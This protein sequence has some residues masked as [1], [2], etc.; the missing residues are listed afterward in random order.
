MARALTYELMREKMNIEAKSRKIS[1]PKRKDRRPI[2]TKK[3][4]KAVIDI[5]WLSKLEGP[6]WF[7]SLKT[8]QIDKCLETGAKAKIIADD[9]AGHS[10]EVFIPKNQINDV[11]FKEN[12]EI[13]VYLEDPPLQ[14]GE[15]NDEICLA[16]EQKADELTQ[17]QTV[18][19][20]LEKKQ[21][22]PGVLM[23][24]VKGGYVVALLAKDREQAEAGVGL[25]AFL[26]MQKSSLVS[27]V[28]LDVL[29][30][31]VQEYLVKDYEP[32][33][34]SIIVSRRELLQQERKK[35]ASQFWAA[36]K[37]DDV[38]NGEVLR[39]VSYGAF[40]DVGGV[41]AFLHASDITW[42]KHLNVASALKISQIVRAK[43][44]ELNK[45]EKKVRLS[46]KSLLADP[47]EELKKK[48]HPGALVEGTVVALADFGVFV[49]LRDGVEGLVHL[50]EISWD[51]CKHPSQKLH[52]GD[53]VKAKVLNFDS[54]EKRISLSL[55]TLE[56]SPIEKASQKYEVGKVYKSKIEAL[57]DFG[58]LLK[59]EDDTVGF[60]K[61]YEISWTRRGIHP[62]K[63]FEQDQEIDVVILGFD[64]ERQRVLCSIRQIMENPWPAWKK[65]F[66]LSTCHDV[67]VTKVGA[68]G[69]ECELE[70]DLMGF[71]PIRELG[72]EPGKKARDLAK[73]GDTLAVKVI[74]FDEKLAKVTLGVKARAKSETDEAYR[75]YLQKQG[76]ELS[77]TKLGDILPKG[78]TSAKEKG[79]KTGG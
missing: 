60:V 1:I 38:V 41:D 63:M 48:F 34:G 61:T 21:I 19:E 18:E 76:S 51:R 17:I 68:N 42:E 67:S 43:I 74:V 14:S 39:L 71:C 64:N 2:A 4:K 59:L 62:S 70:G 27:G 8:V 79:D 3:T 15:K 40:V 46:L 36:T 25:R 24:K 73:V 11:K 56:Q 54:Q 52:I 55:K 20:A 49:K 16:S 10:A 32:T 50:S 57:V 47:W 37:V 45:A 5:S 31:Q 44:V 69:V 13:Q 6:A 26:P 30:N 33:S 12:C 65:K 66:G 9:L 75:E 22:L 78:L 7:N 53:D 35:L 28:E 72:G 58:I 29:T 77:T 23:A